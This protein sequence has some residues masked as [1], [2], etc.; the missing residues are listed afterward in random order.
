MSS[1]LGY[2][3]DSLESPDLISS[4]LQQSSFEILDFKLWEYLPDMFLN[5]PAKFHL[6]QSRFEVILPFGEV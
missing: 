2:Y 6:N 5:L 3:E 1:K 4:F